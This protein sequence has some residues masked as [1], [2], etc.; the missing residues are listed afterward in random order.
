MIIQSGIT[1]RVG[2]ITN[3]FTQLPPGNYLLDAD[4]KGFFLV[5]KEPFT[6]PKRVYGDHS[7]IER[8]KKSYEN[9]SEKNLGILLSGVKGSGK[10]ITA[11][12]FCMEMNM[13]VIL[14]TQ[15]FGGPL[16]T[17]FLTRLGR[18]IV[19]VD[20][21]EKI[22]KEKPGEDG[23]SPTDLLSLMDGNYQ[24]R[25]IFLLTVNA[26]SINEYLVNRLGRIKYRKHYNSLSSD[27]VNDVIDNLLVNKAFG[28]SI[29][30]FFEKV[31]TCTFDLLVNLIKEINLFDEDA[32][33]CG[34]HLN[35]QSEPRWY[36]V[37]EVFEGKDYPCYNTQIKHGN[38]HVRIQRKDTKYITKEHALKYYKGNNMFEDDE[39]EDEDEMPYVP[40][41]IMLVVSDCKMEKIS[42]GIFTLENE[43][44]GYKFKFVL[45]S[46]DKFLF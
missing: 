24:T 30:E 17:D 25:N 4:Q 10:T 45:E 18:V 44:R 2:D 36:D 5:K 21:F 41:D 22:Y 7:I 20:E 35:L 8:W 28:P 15:P 23:H 42:D 38:S 27:V 33:S 43:E 39:E 1:Y 32:I 19:F 37:F 40:N 31:G 29:H 26:M 14:I 46:S 13:P 16:F 34:K 9:N 3:T 6:L 11:Q 12:K